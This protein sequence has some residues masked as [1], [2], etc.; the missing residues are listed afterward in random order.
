MRVNYSNKKFDQLFNTMK[1]MD[2]GPE[3]QRVIGDMF[4]IL[5]KD[6]PWMWGFHPKSFALAHQWYG[7]SKPNFM[8]NNT[9]KYKKIDP[10]LRHQKR[11]AWN[12]PV[13]WPIILLVT[14]M[15]A[16]IIP[17]II[18]FVRKEHTSDKVGEASKT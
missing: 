15:V 4:N 2:N 11:Q 3:R 13:L 6:A 9:M 1:D 17:A 14:M 7:N 12:K 10:V 5:R 16:L 8:A 18:V